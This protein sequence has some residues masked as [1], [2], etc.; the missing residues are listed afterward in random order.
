[1]HHLDV[2]NSVKSENVDANPPVCPKPRRLRSTSPSL[3]FLEHSLLRT[4]HQQTNCDGRRGILNTIDDK[5]R[6][7]LETELGGGGG[8]WCE[9]SSPPRRCE[10]PLVHDNHFL[11]IRR[12][13]YTDVFPSYKTSA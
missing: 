6:T 4:N 12:H 3:Q 11:Q 2:K 13:T 9:S 8:W 5:V 7:D 10:N 1:M